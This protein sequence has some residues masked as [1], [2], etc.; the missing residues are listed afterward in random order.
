MTAPYGGKNF[1]KV[2]STRFSSKKYATLTRYI[3][4]VMLPEKS[5]RQKIKIFLSGNEPYS[6]NFT[7][8]NQ[9]FTGHICSHVTSKNDQE[10]DESAD[11]DSVPD[12]VLLVY[13]DF[14]TTL[15]SVNI[16]AHI[17]LNNG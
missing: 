16:F 14:G 3:L 4:P 6:E 12:S 8:Q 7:R 13:K 15:L 9:F 5:T 1:A 10:C 17:S 2:S 11:S